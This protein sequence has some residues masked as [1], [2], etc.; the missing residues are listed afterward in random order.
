MKQERYFPS[1]PLTESAYYKVKSDRYVRYGCISHY[2][3]HIQVSN[4]SGL[5]TIEV[6]STDA[7]H[8]G[9]RDEVDF[10][11]EHNDVFEY[12]DEKDFKE[13]LDNVQKQIA[14]HVYDASLN[15]TS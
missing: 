14:D 2:G 10:L 4:Y 6:E 5:P 13:Y 1:A 9:L 15:P 11:V 7:T 3:Y 12:I 8:A